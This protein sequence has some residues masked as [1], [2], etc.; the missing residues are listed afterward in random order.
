VFSDLAAGLGAGML[1]GLVGT[2]LM[3]LGFL[4]VDLLLPGELRRHVWEDRNQN[5]AVMLA[6]ALLGLGAIVT[7][8]I[9]TSD[10]ELGAGLADT[11]GYGVLGIVLMALSFLLVDVL[12]PGRLGRLGRMLT[13]PTPHPAAWVTAAA[14]I[15]VA[16]ITAAAIA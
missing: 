12:V 1:S 4:V 9:A 14:N 13:D 7:T 5:A 8:A 6:S 16:A 11:A 2:G 3:V 10:D 15:A